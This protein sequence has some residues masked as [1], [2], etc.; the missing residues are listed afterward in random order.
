M[1]QHRMHK[2]GHWAGPRGFGHGRGFGPGRHFG[3]GAFNPN[4]PEIRALVGDVRDLGQYLFRQGA[5]GGL[6]DT[7]KVKQL[8]EIVGRTRSEI[9]TLFGP[10]DVTT[11]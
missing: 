4:D 11:V 2:R 5:S 6:N 9:E 3:H 1:F 10:E 7:E 8:R